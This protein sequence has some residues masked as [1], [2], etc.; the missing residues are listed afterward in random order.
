M[1]DKKH[2]L[3]GVKSVVLDLDGTLYDKRGL[4]RRMVRR[5]FWCLPLL[6]SERLARRNMHY[7][8]FATGEEFYD[9]FFH[10][11]A[12]GHWWNAKIAAKWYELVYMPAMI[13]L[14]AKRQPIRHEVMDLIA[15][16]KERGIKSNLRALK[17]E[18]IERDYQDT[19]RTHSP[20][21]KADDAIEIDTSDMT[22]VQVT[23]EILKIVESKL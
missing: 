2:V 11:M 20:L 23:D 16:C 10:M 22:I 8:Q 19:H 17:Q 6:A 1:I 15:E 9:C 14:I 21:K 5:L 12:R 13:R 7:L 3:N 18:I 4:A